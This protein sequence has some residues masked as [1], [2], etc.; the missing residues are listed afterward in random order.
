VVVIVVAVVV[1]V[2]VVAVA[3]AARQ[4]QR[5]RALR[6]RFGPEYDRAVNAAGGSKQAEIDLRNRAERRDRLQIRPLNAAQRDRY[7]QDWRQ[8]Q[9]EFV[10]VP[11]TS[12]ARAD[13]LVTDVMVDRG[14]P[15]Q[16]FDLQ[17]D[18]I[19]VDHPAVVDHYRSA[20]AVYV[21]S[22]S[23]PVSTEEMR[24]AFVS[25]RALFSELVDEGTQP[26]NGTSVGARQQTVYDIESGNVGR[27]A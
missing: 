24:R 25:Y 11:E 14:Y 19:S 6:A 17:A 21:L 27:P 9:A 15:M 10:D 16:D 4:R 26:G 2:G 23:Q 1:V 3:L 12:M 18:L 13:R 20:H 7:T 22:R 5:R 8:V